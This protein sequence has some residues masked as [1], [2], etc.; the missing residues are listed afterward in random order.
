MR[1][2]LSRVLQKV[3]DSRKTAI[4]DL[5]LKRLNV[6]IAA[7]QETRLASNGCLREANYIFFWQG[8]EPEEPRIHGVGFAIKNS[9]LKSVEPPSSGTARIL[10]LSLSTSAGP[11]NIFS[12]YAPPCL[13][14]QSQK[15]SSMKSSAT[16]LET[17]QPL[18]I[19]T[20]LVTLM[21]V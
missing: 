15:T 21:R 17:F 10:R 4:I 14:H 18:N 6:D 19:F 20:F 16:P 1:P 2:G 7:L 13:P 9:L 12:V 3:D 8:L 5:E 11:A